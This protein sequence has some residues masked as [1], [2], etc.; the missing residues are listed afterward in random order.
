MELKKIMKKTVIAG[1]ILSLGLMAFTACGGG[2]EDTDAGTNSEASGTV[3]IAGSTSVQPLTEMMGEEFMAANGDIS[4]EVQ[5]GGSG[6][7]IKAIEEKIADFGSLSRELKDEEKGSV[8]EE[9]IIAKDGIAVIVNSET[10]VDNITIEQLKDIYTGKVTN[11]KELGGEDKEIIVVSREEGSG[12]RG[13][14]TEITGVLEK[15]ENGEEMDNT[16]ESA[17]I[18]GSTGA[19]T[20]TVENTPDSIGYISLGSLSDKVKALKVEDVEATTENVLDESYK[21]ARPFIY[22]AGS[23]IS[24]TAQK[25]LDFVM[26]E[27][28]QAV[29]EEAGFIPVK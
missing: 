6:Q 7:G 22:V 12:T 18:Q 10:K 15:D 28:G 9:F 19:V 1:M 3:V 26:S 23:E 20:Q 29:V 16:I 5:G 14:F 17:L 8:S 2:D 11:W 21:L 25:F 13:S 27:D 24:D 4:I